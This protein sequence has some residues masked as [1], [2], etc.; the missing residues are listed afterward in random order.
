MVLPLYGRELGTV[1]DCAS[2][3]P[4]VHQIR[5]HPAGGL[6]EIW[7]VMKSICVAVSL[8]PALTGV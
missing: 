1:L 6:L 4:V 8:T 5:D 2:R 7:A 3:T